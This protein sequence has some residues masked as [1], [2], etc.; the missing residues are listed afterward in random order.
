MKSLNIIFVD[1]YIHTKEELNIYH[2]TVERALGDAMMLPKDLGL[3]ENLTIGQLFHLRDVVDYYLEWADFEDDGEKAN[4]FLFEV[5]KY[6]AKELEEWH[7]TIEG[8]LGKTLFLPKD[9]DLMQNV[10]EAYLEYLKDLFDFFINRKLE[11][12]GYFKD[13]DDLDDEEL[14]SIREDVVEEA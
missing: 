7:Q 13:T 1:E 3:L 12:E 11:D 2:D 10:S 9:I 14:D 8:G 5:D 6:P 4:V